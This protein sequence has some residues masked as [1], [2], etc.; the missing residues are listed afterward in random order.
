MSQ[1]FSFVPLP[2]TKVVIY[3]GKMILVHGISKSTENFPDR[4]I[5]YI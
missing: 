3:L 5:L 1:Y 2:V 4:Y